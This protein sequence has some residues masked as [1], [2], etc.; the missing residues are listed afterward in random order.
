MK[1]LGINMSH[2]ASVCVVEDGEVV[3]ALENGRLSKIKYD[4]K[5]DDLICHLKNNFY[6]VIVYTSFNIN[7]DSKKN[8]HNRYVK[9]ELSKNNITYKKLIC[10]PH[11][12]TTHAFSAFYN[13]GFK[14]AICLIIDN[15]GVSPSIDNKEMGS[16][17]LSI[18]KI[19]NNEYQDIL[20]IHA[21][22]Q[23]FYFETGNT[24]SYSA[25]SP[26][27]LFEMVMTI[28]KYNEPGAVMGRSSYGKEQLYIPKI[29]SFKE[30]KF[31][32]NIR[33]LEQLTR[34]IGKNE[35]DYCY[36]IQ[37]DSTDLVIK[38]LEFIKERFPD[39]DICLSGGY[40]QNCMTNY[41][42]IRKGYN[43][44][45]DPASHDG[46]TC[47]GLAQH[48]Y[49]LNAKKP[50]KKYDDLYLG[51]KYPKVSS[52]FLKGVH[53]VNM[54]TVEKKVEVDEVASLLNKDKI[55]AIYQGRSEF[56]PR[57]LGN[58]SL[59]YN[60]KD[61]LAKDKINGIKKREWFRPY[62][63]TVLHEKKDEWFD[64]YNKEE[65]KY[66]SYAVKIKDDKTRI[67]P[68]VNHIDNTCRVQTLKQTENL[69]FY[70]LI[71]EFEK[72]SG[73]P[74]LL[75]TSLNVAGK[76]LIE[77]PVEAIDFLYNT[78]IDYVYFPEASLLVHRNVV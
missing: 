43:I 30:N 2:H 1:V 37:K 66:M 21:N 55:I 6:D 20:K 50:V 36:R 57:A 54:S 72:V 52:E 61:P 9:H 62:A 15:G 39:Y 77:T 29:Y 27:C 53:I 5:I 34:G 38:Y 69:H 75:N 3:F 64:F 48:F 65:T 31:Y 33:F 8:Y 24:A 68:G 28:F 42:I 32:F 13:S 63:G 59:L 76:P 17:V 58:R 10:F 49:K 71:K 12:H 45:V 51:P 14:K 26:A 78:E 44:F 46:G 70:N 11:H 41:E 73:V 56:G 25:I 74:I 23:N 19:D 60:P 22:N 4:P 47:V 16:E 18:I 40:F 35:E 7:N 67:I